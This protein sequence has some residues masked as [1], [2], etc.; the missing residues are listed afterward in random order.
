MNN[1]MLWFLGRTIDRILYER[2]H[3]ANVRAHAFRIGRF[4]EFVGVGQEADVEWRAS[5]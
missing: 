5:S 4:H 2:E 3:E 1:G